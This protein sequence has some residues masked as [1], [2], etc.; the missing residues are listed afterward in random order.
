M[1][2]VPLT[3]EQSAAL[4]AAGAELDQARA[5]VGIGYMRF[6]EANAAFERAKER[7][8]KDTARAARAE[9]NHVSMMRGLAQI[10]ELPPGKYT[11]DKATGCLRKDASDE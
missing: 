4:A 5:A 1:V 7:L 2:E 10:L 9:A 11:Y 8:D 3:P 6:V